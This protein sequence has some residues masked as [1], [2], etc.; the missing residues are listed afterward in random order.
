MWAVELKGL[1]ATEEEAKREALERAQGT[2][3][4]FMRKHGLN[5]PPLLEAASTLFPTIGA[6]FRLTFR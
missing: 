2:L 6:S 5:P 4:Y 1:G 3:H